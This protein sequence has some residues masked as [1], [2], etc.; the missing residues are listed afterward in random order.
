[1]D[2]WAADLALPLTSCSVNLS[3]P[4]R[5]ER[6][7]MSH[8]S[9]KTEVRQRTKV[10]SHFSRVSVHVCG[11]SWAAQLL[12]VLPSPVPDGRFVLEVL[13][14]I[15]NVVSPELGPLHTLAALLCESLTHLLLLVSTWHSTISP[16]TSKRL[17]SSR[18]LMSLERFRMYTTRPS[19]CRRAT[20]RDL[21]FG[22]PPR[23]RAPTESSS[24]VHVTWLRKRLQLGLESEIGP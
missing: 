15:S 11:D 1:M 3:E 4:P 7:H 13:L 5:K 8:A 23:W 16:N 2:I 20:Q 10:A 6:L 9:W 18:E 21:S 14:G 22:L 12:Q 19:P 24:P 17:F